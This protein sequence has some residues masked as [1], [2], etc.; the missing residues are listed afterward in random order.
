M[1]LPN[2]PPPRRTESNVVAEV[3]AALSRI[4]GVICYRNNTGALRDATGRL[5]RYGLADGSADLVACAW[6]RFVAIECK[7]EQPRGKPSKHLASQLAWIAQLEAHGGIGGVAWDVESALRILDRARPQ[8]TAE[9]P[10][11]AP[12][13]L[14]ATSDT[15]R[16]PRR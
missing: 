1:Q 13:A 4:P 2:R 7:L 5:V 15:E 12:H 8:P 11:A 14:A 6:G 10:A 3:R 9:P 16:A